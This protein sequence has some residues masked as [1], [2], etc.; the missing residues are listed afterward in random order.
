[1]ERLVISRALK[2]LGECDE[3]GVVCVNEGV[4][5]HWCCVCEHR[6][7]CMNAGVCVRAVVCVF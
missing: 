6:C 4:Y 5:E 1:M 2:S 7:V 3:M